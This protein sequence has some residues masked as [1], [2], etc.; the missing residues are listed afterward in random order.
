MSSDNPESP[1]G[2]CSPGG[3][4]PG[5]ADWARTP[6]AMFVAGILAIASI[7]GLAW[8]VKRASTQDPIAQYIETIPVERQAEPIPSVVQTIDI[9]SAS[10]AQLELLP[11][12][13]PALSGRIIESRAVDGRF[14]RI[15]DLDRVPGIGPKTIEK[16][17]A[18]AVVND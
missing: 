6:S 15:E 2:S 13:G 18:V 16:L 9:N 4:D 8:S 17:R 3:S 7:S 1:K 12:I 5:S 10:A 14:D 11:S